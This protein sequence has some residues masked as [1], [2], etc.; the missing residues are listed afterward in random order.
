MEKVVGPCFY[1]VRKELGLPNDQ[2][3]LIR[4]DVLKGQSTDKVTKKVKHLNITKTM[5]PKIMTQLLHALKLS[6]NSLMEKIE[7]KFFSE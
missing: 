6:I 5:V 2:K 3:A 4:W 1:Q 7:K